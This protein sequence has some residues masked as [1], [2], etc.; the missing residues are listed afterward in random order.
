MAD[1]RPSVRIAFPLPALSRHSPQLWW[2]FAGL[3]VSATC[4]YHPEPPLIALFSND[5]NYLSPTLHSLFITVYPARG[6]SL[7][8]QTVRNLP[9][10]QETQVQSLGRE[11]PLEKEP[12]TL[13]SILAWRIPQT[14]RGPV[15]L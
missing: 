3:C 4:Q 2:P 8:A 7:L 9:A 11:D 14:K 5:I 6:G 10:M 1:E 12:A 13:S 15:G